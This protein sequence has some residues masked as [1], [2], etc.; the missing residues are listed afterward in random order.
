MDASHSLS[1]GWGLF[2]WASVLLLVCDDGWGDVRVLLLGLEDLDEIWHDLGDVANL[3]LGTLHNLD[4]ESDN[5]L[6]EFD[7]SD[8]AVDEIVLGLTGGDLVT[9]SVL[10]GLGTLSTDL[11][12]DD[13]FATDGTTSSHDGS[14]NVV[15]GKSDW[16]T[17]EELVL[18]GL[19]VGGGAEGLLVWE[20]LD[21]E[22]K[23]VVAIVEVVSLL[24]EGLDLLHFTGLLVE[25]VLALGGADTD[26]SGHAG[27]TDFDTGVSLETEDLLEE[28]VELGLENSVGNEL[29]LGVD[30]LD[31]LV[32]HSVLSVRNFNEYK[33]Q[34]PE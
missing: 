10:L 34:T 5:T 3:D 23:F 7:G 32:C 15:G 12:G 4:L 16:G 21:G 22:L 29:F 2:G 13:D 14:E 18:E 6:S 30:L 27:G 19:D 20:W 8:G 17:S 33:L 24:D 26:L 1:T 25:E 11:T 31:F 28:L 9:L